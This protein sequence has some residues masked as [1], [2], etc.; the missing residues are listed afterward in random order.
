MKHPSLSWLERWH[1]RLIHFKPSLL[2]NNEAVE[3]GGLK[4]LPG[5]GS[6][7]RFSGF[8]RCVRLTPG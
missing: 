3:K 8:W 1:S 4:A 2:K 5:S 6:L 7:P